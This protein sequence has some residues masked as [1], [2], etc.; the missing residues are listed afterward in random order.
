M[1]SRGLRSIL[2]RTSEA[3]GVIDAENPITA[4][5]SVN[6]SR[7]KA[8]DPLWRPPRA[9]LPSST[10]IMGCMDH[11]TFRRYAATI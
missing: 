10:L 1:R 3:G 9:S 6:D 11:K 8:S 5:P 4:E 2:L 7:I